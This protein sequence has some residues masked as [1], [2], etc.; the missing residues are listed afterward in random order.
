LP[1]TNPGSSETVTTGP[2][3]DL[4]EYDVVLANSSAGKDS[5][6]ALDVVVEAARAADVLDRMVVV[7]AD[8]GDNEWP[9][10]AELAAEHAAHYGLRFEVV[11]RQRDGHVET[12]LERV[13]ERGMWPDAARRWCTSDHKRG[14]IRKL[15]TQLA[16]EQRDAGV[17]GRPVRLLNV[18]GF[19]AEESSA[20][21]RRA[22]YEFDKSASNGRRHVDTWLPIH[23]W[24]TGQVWQRIEQARTQPHPAYAAGMSRLS[25][26]FC[27]LA[28]RSDL[29]CS[30]RLNPELAARY[31]AVEEQTGH[32]FRQDLSMAEVITAAQR[33]DI[34][35]RAEQVALFQV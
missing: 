16:A 19:R 1:A 12:I 6:A 24:T 32:R 14:P 26:R 17:T 20:R 27:V 2:V 33:S 29:I 3:P 25:C 22:P 34:G 9:E 23:G 7:H 15:M 31:A 30:A 35:Q 21:Q 8:L 4:A 11:S 5:Q 18:M 10:T 13:A 28:S